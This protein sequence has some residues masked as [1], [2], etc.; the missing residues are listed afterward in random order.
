MKKLLCLIS[1]PDKYTKERYEEGKLYEFND[2]RAGE[3]LSARTKVTNEPYFEEY[4]E[5][6]TT[7][8]EKETPVAIETNEIVD[9]TNLKVDELR[10][11]AK[12]YGIKGYSSMN[13]KELIDALEVKAEVIDENTDN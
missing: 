5:P 3:I 13:K 8:D 7:D 2:D 12:L 10:D 1:V 9:I 6:D 11:I 4:V